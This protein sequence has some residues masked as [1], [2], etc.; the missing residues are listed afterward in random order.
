VRRQEGGRVTR[1]V[2]RTR[3]EKMANK[4]YRGNELMNE[5]VCEPL[6]LTFAMHTND[7]SNV[8]FA[9]T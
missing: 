4:E 1:R 7:R 3:V 8:F 6:S 9:L 5:G 2:I